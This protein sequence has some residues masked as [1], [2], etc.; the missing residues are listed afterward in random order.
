[1][2]RTGRPKAE[3][4]LTDDERSTLE[5]F[6]RRRKTSQSVALRSRIV[7]A[8]SRELDN[9]EV[10]ARLGVT[11]GTVGKW[12]SRFVDK[13]LDGLFDAPRSGTPR[14]IDDDAVEKILVDTLEKMPKGASRWSTRDM[15]KKAGI[16]HNTVA[17][18]WRAFGLKP[19]RAE[20]FQL[21]TDPDF[22]EKVRDVVGLYLS[23]PS[24]AVVLSVDEKSQIQA[25]NRTQPL[26]PLG[27][28][29]IEKRTPEYERH[30]TT[31]LFAALDV[32][33]GEVIGKCFRRH[34]TSEFIA[35]LRL[36]DKSIDPDLDVHIV[37]DNLATHKTEAVLR[38]IVRHPR[39]HLHFIPTHSSWLNQVEALFSIL[40]EKQLKRGVHRSVRAVEAAVYEF[41][42]ATNED[43]K[44]FE[45]KKTADQIL[46][47]IARFCRRTLKRHGS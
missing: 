38:W 2:P 11:S 4:I 7:L 24:N 43:A 17:K 36:I 32:A 10:A 34:R 6:T 18:I 26:L 44:P 41:L 14:K 27:P 8:C 29:D 21:S 9:Q 30:G 22:V 47:S 40:E 15:A 25:L 12:R 37:L 23:P 28:G 5:R 39:F 45:W 20:T 16:S 13:R 31:S 3:L 33:T 1:M 19:H 35:F 46:D 42:D